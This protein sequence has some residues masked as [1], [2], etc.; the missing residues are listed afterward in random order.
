MKA[1]KMKKS[2]SLAL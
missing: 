2:P 1:H